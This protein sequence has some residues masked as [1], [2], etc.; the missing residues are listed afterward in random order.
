M[1]SR[2][3]LYGRRNV[4]LRHATPGDW[5]EALAKLETDPLLRRRVSGAVRRDVLWSFGPERATE[6]MGL[7]L[8]LLRGGRYAARAFELDVLRRRAERATL[9]PLPEHG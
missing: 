2:E 8:D 1:V 7:L 5:R 3:Q 6:A 4:G 9:P